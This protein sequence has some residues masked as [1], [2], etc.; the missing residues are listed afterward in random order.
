MVAISTS[1]PTR[2]G[3]PA[4]VVVAGL[5]ALTLVR[6]AVAGALNLTDDEAYYRLWS[7]SLDFGYYDHAPMVAWI[8]RAGRSL[9]GDTSLGLRLFAPVMALVGSL[10]LWR[11]AA[12]LFGT[13]RAGTAVLWYNATALVAIGSIV[14]TPDTPSVFFWGATLWA[15]AELD[16]SR[17]ANWWLVVGLTSGLCLLSKYSGLFLGAGIVLW[18]LWLPENRRWL[19][20]WQLWLGGLIAV[21]MFVPVIVW[22]AEHNWVSFAKQF[23]RAVVHDLTPTAPLELI[24][25]TA[26]LL[27]GLIVP[28]VVWG[29]ALALGAGRTDR[30]VRNAVLPLATSLPFALYL[31]QHSLHGHVEANWPA[32]LFQGA[33]LLAVAPLSRVADLAPSRRAM[34]DWL[35]RWTGP[36]GIVLGLLVYLHAL[37]PIW[38]LSSRVD[39]TSQT[40]GWDQ[41]AEEIDQR[42]REVGAEWIAGPNYAITA[43]LIRRLGTDR[44]LQ[45]TERDRYSFLPPPASDI[46]QK[47]ALYLARSWHPE[48]T[49]VGTLF[50]SVERLPDMARTQNGRVVEPYAVFKVS[51]LR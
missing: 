10:T 20:S 19:L 3:C 31:L 14:T 21:A 22:N 28:F 17:N 15:L 1:A 11:T 6:F 26:G 25:T 48:A 7:F 33:V 39:P 38:I 40:R 34:A 35:R 45:P 18:I 50:R 12:I 43:Q 32:P 44:V 46:W 27:S 49:R 16:R 51:G 23:G 47:P 5:V 41:F 2:I 30:T 42:A 9:V 37:Y 8:M 24:G 29:T 4:S 13:S 36:F